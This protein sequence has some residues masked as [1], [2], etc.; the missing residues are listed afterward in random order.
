MWLILSGAI[1]RTFSILNVKAPTSVESI[2]RSFSIF[3]RPSI[4][5][6][7]MGHGDENVMTSIYS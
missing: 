6:N 3:H 7:I 2:S 5:A 1:A 4:G